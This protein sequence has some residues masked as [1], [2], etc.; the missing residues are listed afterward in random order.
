MHE[1]EGTIYTLDNEIEINHLATI[2]KKLNF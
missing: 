1:K 2:T